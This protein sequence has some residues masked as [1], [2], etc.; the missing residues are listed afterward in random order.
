MVARP[1]V[2]AAEPAGARAGAARRRRRWRSRS[3]STPGCTTPPL[4]RCSCSASPGMLQLKAWLATAA[5]VLVVVQVAHGALDVGPPPRRRARPRLAAHPAP[6]ERQRGLHAHPA[7]R[8]ALRLVARLRHDDAA[9]A[10]ARPRRLR[11][12]RRL[13][14]QDARPAAARAC[15]AGP[16]RCSA[17]RCSPCSSWSGTTS[18]LWFFTRSGVPLL[19]REARRR[20]RP[21]P[22]GAAERLAR[23]AGRGGG[24]LPRGARTAR[25]PGRSAARPRPTPTAPR[26][27]PP[28]GGALVALDDVPVGGGVVLTGETRRGHPAGAG[29]RPRVL[30]RVHPPG[31][32]GRHGGRRDHRLPLPRQPVRRGHRRGAARPGGP[33]AAAGAGRRPVR[34]GGHVMT[35]APAPARRRTHPALAAG[36]SASRSAPSIALG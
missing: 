6:L 29:R 17:A 25:P 13:R 9:G 14:G 15:P 32:H 30:R 8:A 10:R 23:R 21:D 7:G 16:S 19:V 28:A 24:R 31:V 2:S 36:R 1:A 26:P 34:G 3:A 22:P 5:L 4:G 33:A 12:L 20:A 27:R 18:A 35:A 11:L